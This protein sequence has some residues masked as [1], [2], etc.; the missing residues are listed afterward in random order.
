MQMSWEASGTNS[1]WSPQ[2][3]IQ[4]S[5]SWPASSW[6]VTVPVILR[7]IKTMTL[8]LLMLLLHIGCLSVCC[9]LLRTANS[10]CDQ[11]SQQLHRKFEVLCVG[12]SLHPY[13]AGG[14]NTPLTVVQPRVQDIATLIIYL[15]TYLLN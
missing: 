2:S 6:R 3:W 15:L 9:A 7:M 8:L 13:V 4:P 12:I 10:L 11:L 14:M 5:L 1:A